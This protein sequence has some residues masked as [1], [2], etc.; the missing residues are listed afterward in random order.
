MNLDDTEHYENYHHEND[1][2]EILPPYFKAAPLEIIPP[3]HEKYHPIT[4]TPASFLIHHDALEK[5]F[6]G[7]MQSQL[8]NPQS[9][10]LLQDSLQ[11]INFHKKL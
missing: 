1:H 5:T 9:N 11:L 2:H 4:K 7:A 10:P 8:A 6:D 3:H